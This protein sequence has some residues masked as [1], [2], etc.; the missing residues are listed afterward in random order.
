MKVSA[1]PKSSKRR[2]EF[3]E[4]AGDLF[5][6]NGFDNVSID[7][8]IARSGGSKTSIYRDFGGKDAL[9]LESIL[10]RCKRTLQPIM[11]PIPASEDPVAT[12][13]NFG[14]QFLK[15]VLSEDG[16]LCHRIVMAEARRFPEVGQ[17]FYAAGPQSVYRVLSK[18]FL[19]IE[20][21]SRIAKGS[22]DALARHFHGM[23][24]TELQM[25]RLLANIPMPDDAQLRS[26][27]ENA[28]KTLLPE[29]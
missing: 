23:I 10:Q 15:C 25:A 9:F 7:D 14:V 3:L 26:H 2:E 22:A 17:A 4:A 8:I 1:T 6:R 19:Q 16:I 12:L 18:I 20:K 11:R 29:P 28:I 13:L 24:L 5:L 21:Q 27:V